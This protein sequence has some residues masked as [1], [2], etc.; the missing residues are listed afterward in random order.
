MGFTLLKKIP[1][2]FIVINYSCQSHG[3]LHEIILARYLH[4]LC[5]VSLDAK[6]RMVVFYKHSYVE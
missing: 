6:Q 5:W 3:A 1:I 2:K 4:H